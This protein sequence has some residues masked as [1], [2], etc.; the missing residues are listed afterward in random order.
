MKSSS[1]LDPTATAISPDLFLNDDFYSLKCANSAVFSALRADEDSPDADLHRRISAN[2]GGNGHSGTSLDVETTGHCYYKLSDKIESSEPHNSIESSRNDLVAVN[3]KN[4]NCDYLKDVYETFTHTHSIELP[5]YLVNAVKETKLSSLMGLLHEAKIVWLSVDDILYLWEYSKHPDTVGNTGERKREDFVRFQ[6][7][8][9][10]CIVSVGLVKPK[11]G[12]FRDIVEWCL[13][14]TTSEDVLLC[15]LARE[16]NSLSSTNCDSILKL[17]PTRYIIPTDSVPMLSICGTDDGRVF[18]GGHDGC[19]YEMSY[20]G[21]LPPDQIRGEFHKNSFSKDNANTS[22]VNV[23]ASG[24]KRALSTFV[25]GSTNMSEDY[26]RPRKCRKLNH[27]THAPDLLS[28]FIPGI[29][30]R[31]TSTVLGGGVTANSGPIVDMI[32]D[33]Y[34]N[35][36]YLLTA[37]GF[38]HALDIDTGVN[39]SFTQNSSP[40]LA[41]TVDVTKSVLKYLDCVAHGRMNGVTFSANEH[42]ATIKFPGGSIGTQPGVGG[43]DGARSILKMAK[44]E[45]D[46]KSKST[47]KN[48]SILPDNLS[49]GALHPISIHIVPPSESKNLTLVAISAGGLRYYMSVLRDF[50]RQNTISSYKPGRRFSLIHIRAPPPIS[51]EYNGKLDI[52]SGRVSLTNDRS[53]SIYCV[54]PGF[55]SSRH[56]LHSVSNKGLYH[57][58]ATYLALN[59]NNG[60]NES[61]SVMNTLIALSPD[62]TI[63]H[64]ME[65]NN[66]L[67]AS[68]SSTV[69]ENAM[70]EVIQFSGHLY[71]STKSHLPGGRIWDLKAV[72]KQASSSERIRDLFFRSCTPTD[73]ELDN[74]LIPPYFPP[75]SSNTSHSTIGRNV[76]HINS[77]FD[78]ANISSQAAKDNKAQ[79]QGIVSN[80][81]SAIGDILLNRPHNISG[82]HLSTHNPTSEK[83]TPKYQISER[84]GCGELGF[85]PSIATKSLSRKS[86]INRSSMLRRSQRDIQKRSLALPSSLLEPI[87]VPLSSM[88]LQHLSWKSQKQAIIALNSGGLHFFWERSPIQKLYDILNKSNIHNIGTDQRLRQ[89]FNCF[90]ASESCAMCLSIAICAG[91]EIV[92]K[93]A[94]QASLSF[95]CRP[96][97]LPSVNVN[98]NS[99][100]VNESIRDDPFIY[101]GLEAFRF[102]P[103]Y[104]YRGLVSLVSRLLRPIWCKPAVVVDSQKKSTGI[105]PARVEFLLD[106]VT[107]E[108]IRRPIS[109]LRTLMRDMFSPVVTKVPANDGTDKVARFDVMEVDGSL[110][111]KFNHN[112]ISPSMQYQSQSIIQK[113]D[114]NIPLQKD[115]SL[116]A[117]LREDRN[118]HAL[119][120]LVSRTVQLLTLI[121][122]L[123]LAHSTPELAEVEF[124]FLHGLTFSQL[125]TSKHAQERIDFIL[126]TLLSC[127]KGI[128]SR[129]SIMEV[130]VES[131]N[132]SLLLSQQ[133]Y[134]YLSGGSRL[135]YLGF[136]TAHAAKS[137]TSSSMKRKELAENSVSYFCGAARSWANPSQVV[138][139]SLS[140]KKNMNDDT[141]ESNHISYH[142]LAIVA[143]EYGSALARSCS[144]LMN[145]MHVSGIVKLCL[146]CASNFG[147]VISDEAIDSGIL[148]SS[149]TSPDIL[150]WEK[151][152]YQ[153]SIVREVV[154]DSSSLNLHI[155]DDSKNEK[156][157]SRSEVTYSHARQT[158]YALLFYHLNKLIDLAIQSYEYKSLVERMISVAVASPDT[159]FLHELYGYLVSS[160]NTDTLLRIQSPSLEKWLRQEQ[161]DYLLLWKFYVVHELDW[162]AGEVMWQQGCSSLDEK[163]SL[164]DRIQCLTRALAS[165]NNCLKTNSSSRK[166]VEKQSVLSSFHYEK[167][168]P[169]FEEINRR[170]SQV[171][172]QLDVSKIQIRV[173]AAVQQSQ[174]K[175]KVDQILDKD[176]DEAL[177]YS[178]LNVS[179]LYNEYALPLGLYDI[180][181]LILNL[182]HYTDPTT[183]I[184]MWNFLFCEELVPCRTNSS[185]V[186]EFLGGLQEDSML[187]QESI[188]LSDA[189]ILD[190]DGLSVLVFEEGRWIPS[191]KNRIIC[192]GKE[193]YGK[194]NDF[195]F[196]VNFIVDTLEGINFIYRNVSSVSESWPLQTLVEVGVSF[197]S[198]LDAYNTKYSRIE[199]DNLGE[200]STDERIYLL[201]AINDIILHWISAANSQDKTVTVNGHRRQLI[202]YSNILLSQIDSYKVSLESIVGC[203][204]EEASKLILSFCNTE[205]RIQRHFLS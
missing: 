179:V 137:Y 174:N 196:P 161:K 114:S 63:K 44:T 81:F 186:K 142:Q 34:R 118:I 200:S 19:L 5:P 187:H 96:H 56:S 76:Q 77:S 38:I 197:Q 58:G 109:V 195:T 55:D 129:K 144:I 105:L 130:S 153:S 52:E 135:M 72:S 57:S 46:L 14:V 134:L 68:I 25:F 43:M 69:E 59:C 60:L 33:E 73:L 89:F 190:E 41:C 120:R 100:I 67:R 154:S 103:S 131:N 112:S 35:I 124:G 162:M 155:H 3:E 149:D 30:L 160:G 31:A 182:C 189:N 201:Q 24:S 185:V 168:L 204:N 61:E 32:L 15:A 104:L 10:H 202:C 4:K 163:I 166:S 116:I 107:L 102:M 151:G 175:S 180:C 199:K 117:R 70:N 94:R 62:Y 165:Y 42:I 150:S 205:T 26:Y 115:L 110:Q 7:P 177:L 29:V 192:L 75:T 139:V 91:N 37:N 87:T 98:E 86:N 121:S 152:L 11:K 159:Y 12:V 90:G 64:S 97:M 203:M 106:E 176:K 74:D 49:G 147:G 92:A 148:N 48:D 113:E 18:M 9:G 45:M 101:N 39:G 171:T 27:S 164:D 157:T 8:S 13:L 125:V 36:M 133:C 170:I 84:V 127:D 85:S 83:K 132:L 184:T 158:C 126:T 145:L 119:Y 193:I 188:I 99:T 78:A 53:T 93:K 88:A 156:V 21:A 167:G 140:E 80:V 141:L 54:K 143:M 136:R 194:G 111:S 22:M 79:S 181:I 82:K 198:L 71:D 66:G 191:L 40:R 108:E 51:F 183:I 47:A 50:G 28:A 6:V 20:E 146:I 16:S 17:I 65:K 138:G 2:A 1:R 123:R 23:I 95:A 122:Q 128:S 169:S 172:E 173:L 178:L